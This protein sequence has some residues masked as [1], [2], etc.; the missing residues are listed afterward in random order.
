MTTEA[1]FQLL[2]IGAVWSLDE[3]LIDRLYSFTCLVVSV[4][5]VYMGYCLK[6]NFEDIISSP[7]SL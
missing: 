7:A 5:L 6:H 3:M 1:A 2:M 4:L